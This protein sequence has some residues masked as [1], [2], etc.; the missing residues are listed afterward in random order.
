MTSGIAKICYWISVKNLHTDAGQEQMFNIVAYIMF[1]AIV[2]GLMYVINK[3]HLTIVYISSMIVIQNLFQNE[4]RIILN[5]DSFI[6]L[7]SGVFIWSKRLQRL[8]G[9]FG[10]HAQSIYT[11]DQRTLNMSVCRLFNVCYKHSPERKN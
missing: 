8:E 2:S 9:S 1:M 4:Y 11:L 6:F 7:V 10:D 5:L 3:I